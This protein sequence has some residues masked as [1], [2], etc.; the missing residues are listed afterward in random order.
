[1]LLCLIRP[2][3]DSKPGHMQASVHLCPPVSPPYCAPVSPLDAQP[4]AGDSH[5][6]RAD[7]A[8]ITA[9]AVDHLQSL[10][11][12]HPYAALPPRCTRIHHA[13]L[14]LG[15][16][17]FRW[18]MCT[19]AGDDFNGH[20]RV[21]VTGGRLECLSVML[22]YG[23]GEELEVVSRLRFACARLEIRI[24][25]DRDIRAF[26][27]H[28]CAGIMVRHCGHLPRPWQ[29]QNNT[30]G[31]AIWRLSLS[32]AA[33]SDLSKLRGSSN[34]KLCVIEHMIHASAPPSLKRIFPARRFRKVRR[35]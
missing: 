12:E 2:H 32:G 14:A 34:V 35:A 16:A 4:P 20:A 22:W 27:T 29:V 26:G 18:G 17:L 1:M 23:N 25:L 21:R 13:A 28:F 11:I 10:R 15:P 5:L 19:R 24:E 7:A 30:K 3:A 8:F 9:N 6:R 31:K 33:S